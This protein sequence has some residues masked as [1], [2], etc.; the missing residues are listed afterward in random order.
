MWGASRKGG[1]L[2]TTTPTTT[3]GLYDNPKTPWPPPHMARAFARMRVLSAWYAGDPEQLAMVHGGLYGNDHP[4]FRNGPTDRP[5]QYRGGIV[6]TVARWFWGTPTPPG[7]KRAKLHVPLAGDIATLSADLLFA[8]S[9][10]FT[11]TDPAA[12]DAWDHMADA[13]MLDATLLEAA[14]V[15]APLGGVYLAITWDDTL[16]GHPFLRAVHADAAI[17]EW[18]W[19]RL[20]AVTFWRVLDDDDGRVWRHLERHEPGRILHGLYVGTTDVLG[21]RVPL[22]TRRETAG[23]KPI[24]ETVPG[25]LTVAY[26][27]NLRPNR[28]DRNSPLGRS[29]FSAGVLTLMDALDETYSSW[30][31]D[32]RL[33]K[34][35]LVVPRA[36]LQHLGPGQGARFDPER[37]I[38]EALDAMPPPDGGLALTPTSFAIR[39]N[40]HAATADNLVNTIIGRCGYSAQSIGE[41]GEVALTA[42]EVEARERRSFITSKKKTRYWAAELPTL[43][44]TLL[45][46]WAAKFDGRVV[47]ERPRVELAKNIA[48]APEALARTIGL[49]DAANAI[50]TEL[51]VRR[52][53]P[54]WDD[55]EVRDEV[56]RILRETG[57]GPLADPDQIT[58]T[59]P[60]TGTDTGAGP[61]P[62]ADG[63][64]EADTDPDTDT[65]AG[66]E[67]GVGATPPTGTPPPPRRRD[68][69]AIRAIR[70]SRAAR[71][72]L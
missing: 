62:G 4:F 31:R 27:P 10:T 3:A 54:D 40:E 58:V 63:D 35:R 70:A 56:E 60:D 64:L 15:A 44:E 8:E 45:M 47:P 48:E 41:Q 50:S 23:L 29:D 67:G 34:H 32:L 38:F 11:F 24:V 66:P 16:F 52:L 33:A 2:N 25:R 43:A 49:L 1:T 68:T 53:N 36:Y 55:T 28:E 5:S 72:R 46:L 59:N 71:G 69:R 30:M 39:V 51:K 26:V 7:E 14:E 37:E 9:A 13:S 61:D 42:T 19:G 65:G 21:P 17:P 6:G 12:Q 18:R 20:S 22:T 57:K